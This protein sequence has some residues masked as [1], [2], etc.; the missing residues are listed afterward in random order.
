MITDD[1]E[2]RFIDR[3][4]ASNDSLDGSVDR[5]RRR[6]LSSCTALAAFRFCRNNL[7]SSF[8]MRSFKAVI[9]TSA[10]I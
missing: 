8:S 7:R 3:F 9:L 6:C 1:E 5:I 4:M 2:E 10:Y